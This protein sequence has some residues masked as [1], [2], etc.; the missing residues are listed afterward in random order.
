MRRNGTPED[1]LSRPGPLAILLCL[2]HRGPQT[3]QDLETTVGVQ[4]GTIRYHIAAMRDAGLLAID[5]RKP[6]H[7]LLIDEKGV[8]RALD[9]LRPNWRSGGIPHGDLW[10]EAQAAIDTRRIRAKYLTRMRFSDP[11]KS[12]FDSSPKRNHPR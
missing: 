6:A 11:R 9:K 3:Y 1:L 10:R 5:S 7:I 4:S 2:L 12:A 8:T